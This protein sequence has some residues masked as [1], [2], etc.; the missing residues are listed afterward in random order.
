MVS[1]GRK[2]G[3]DPVPTGGVSAWKKLLHEVRGKDDPGMTRGEIEREWGLGSSRTRKLL[4][5][6][7]RNGRVVVGKKQ[8]VRSDG[9]SQKVPVYE[10]VGK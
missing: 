1:K 10:I 7:V 9:A 5:D 8:I 4:L 6:M 2:R 3:S